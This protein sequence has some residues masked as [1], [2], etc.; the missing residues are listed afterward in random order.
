ME[1]ALKKFPEE[2]VSTTTLLPQIYTRVGNYSRAVEIW[3]MGINKGYLYNLNSELYQKYYK[4][5]VDFARLAEI[6]KSRLDTLHVKHEII[7]PNDFNSEKTYPALF[8]F[9]GNHRNITKSK[10][11]WKAPIMN[12]EFITIFLQ[13]YIPATFTDFKWIPDDEKTK[14]EVAEIFNQVI[15]NYPIDKNK[16][17]FSGMSAGGRKALDFTLNNDFPVTGL[18]LNCPVVPRNISE[19]MIKQFVAKNKKL[20]II[21]GENDFA[22]LRQ[23]ELV[24]AID[25]LSGSAKIIV[26]EGLG[27]EFAEDFTQL[28][29][30]YLGWAIQ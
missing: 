22:L 3:Q 24:T 7:L 10:E 26:N 11:V 17:I 23:K 19:D 8:I 15:D 5:N 16:I 25:S 4:D 9:H 6:E 28:L 29:D 14:I 27:H 21:T 20:G 18:V 30:E 2:L 13:S 12:R 1:Y